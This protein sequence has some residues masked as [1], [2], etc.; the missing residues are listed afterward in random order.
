[1]HVGW[2][3]RLT[4]EHTAPYLI[5]DR[6]HPSAANIFDKCFIGSELTDWIMNTT[7]SSSHVKVRSRKQAESM[8][9]V[10]YENKVIYAGKQVFF[11]YTSNSQL[12]FLV[13]PQST[14]EDSF[15]DRYAFYRFCFDDAE[16]KQAQMLAN[17]FRENVT[18]DQN[19]ITDYLFENLSFLLKMAP[20]A[21][22]RQILRK[23]YRIIILL[24]V[25]FTGANL[26]SGERKFFGLKYY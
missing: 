21:T 12:F 10:L 5:R 8:Y 7:M 6:K 15:T 3:I 1:M 11:H 18:V 13:Y 24:S 20:E 17:L 25:R 4:I 2:V 22:L 26:G 19:R 14:E 16:N 9:Q 23:R